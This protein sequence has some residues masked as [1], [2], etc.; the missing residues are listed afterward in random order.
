M[1]GLFFLKEQTLFHHWIILWSR[2]LTCCFSNLSSRLNAY[3]MSISTLRVTTC[4]LIRETYKPITSNG[5]CTLDIHS[6]ISAYW[7]CNYTGPTHAS[8]LLDICLVKGKATI[9]LSE[10]IIRTMISNLVRA[11]DVLLKGYIRTLPVNHLAG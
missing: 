9:L 3:T 11:R 6:G 2:R 10:I 5:A 8:S 1:H 4:V 7:S